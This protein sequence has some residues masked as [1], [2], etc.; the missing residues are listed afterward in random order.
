MLKDEGSRLAVCMVSSVQRPTGGVATTTYHLSKELH[1]QG[2]PIYILDTRYHTEKYPPPGVHLEVVRDGFL[3][4]HN[5]AVLLACAVRKPMVLPRLML[6]LARMRGAFGLRDL[7]QFVKHIAYV[8]DVINRHA[9]RILHTHHCLLRALAVVLVAKEYGLKVVTHIYA[10]EF[11][12]KSNQRYLPI[13]RY[14]CRESDRLIAISEHTR[15]L[16]R[17]CGIQADIDVIPLGVDVETFQP[18]D[19]VHG[20]DATLGLS[21]SDRLVLYAG[22]FTERKGPQVLLKAI[23]QLP[24]LKNV[25]FAFIGPDHG[26]RHWME[27]FVQNNNLADR[28]ALYEPIEHHRMPA[29]YSRADLFVFPTI[30]QDEGFGLVA[31]EAMACGT[32]VVASNIAAIPE[33]V[34]DGETGLLSTPNDETDLANKIRA[35]VEDDALREKM[36]RAGRERVMK[37]FQW[38][39]I[40]SRVAEIYEQLS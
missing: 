18:Q 35:L 28:V 34:A 24:D 23:L 10:S 33:V 31:A 14:V 19:G 38:S 40:A 8:V 27:E 20:F 2:I 3:E 4:R 13:A 30:T 6:T 39:E 16:A 22:W 7:T 21:P 1:S 11:S 9:P 37:L 29:L 15:R 17:A 25:R 26:L 12:M 32:P 36:G 5:L